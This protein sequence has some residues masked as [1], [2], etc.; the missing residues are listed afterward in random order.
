MVPR[1]SECGASFVQR[2]RDRQ[3]LLVYLLEHE[4]F[5]AALLAAVF[6]PLDDGL[7]WSVRHTVD[8][9]NGH[10]GRTQDDDLAVV[11]N[12]RA[13]GMANEGGDRGR[14]EQLLITDPD[15]ERALLPDT[16]QRLRLVIA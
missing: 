8:V 15:Y 3:G 11:Q 16:N 13:A 7:V 1:G 10:L 6:V 14:D 4:R 12:Y 9:E 2:L 5:E